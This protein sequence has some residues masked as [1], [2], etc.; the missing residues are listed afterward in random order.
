MVVKG[1]GVEANPA[2]APQSV[3]MRKR[4]DTHFYGRADAEK[5]AELG[6]GA[7][8]LD[9]GDV[10]QFGEASTGHPFGDKKIALLIEGGVM[11]VDEF[12]WQPFVF[13]SQPAEA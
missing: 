8:G 9:L 4:Q 1:R 5:Y 12:S 10:P 7:P 11:R 13:V 6:L 3:M 2:F